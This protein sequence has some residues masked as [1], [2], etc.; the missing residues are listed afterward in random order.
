MHAVLGRTDSDEPVD[1][2]V[3]RTT[4]TA[5]D[6][7]PE[8]HGAVRTRAARLWLTWLGVGLLFCGG[9]M[10]TTADGPIGGILTLAM[11]LLFSAGI[12]IGVLV[13]KPRPRWPWLMLAAAGL[14]T[15]A[16]YGIWWAGATAVAFPVFI[17]I[18]PL[19]AAALLLIVRGCAL[20]PATRCVP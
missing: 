20:S 8:H 18:Y 9:Q 10:L 4:P 13:N 16:G 1:V 3:I 2:A 6:A 17:T 7:G 12:V 15:V 5:P 19:E 14:V 11:P